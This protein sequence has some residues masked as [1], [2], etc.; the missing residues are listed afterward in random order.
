M[1][2]SDVRSA[3]NEDRRET[4]RRPTA[5]DAVVFMKFYELWDTPR[6]TEAYE[7]FYKITDEAHTYERFRRLAPRGS[8]EY[9]LV[10]RVLSSFEQAGVL[11]KHGLMHPA[12]F[13][14]GWTP[15]R[16][17]W[18]RAM[19]FVLGIR[20]EGNPNAY[21]NIEWLANE[22]RTY[23][24]QNSGESISTRFLNAQDSKARP[25]VQ[26]DAGADGQG[27]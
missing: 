4:Q 21:K 15:V 27:I 12:L 2:Q 9:T 24:K 26:P 16:R 1:E 3:A 11:M 20:A 13:F 23:W 5:D 14:E 17:I 19:P 22:E 10:D 6:D 8:H 18:E 25:H 7:F